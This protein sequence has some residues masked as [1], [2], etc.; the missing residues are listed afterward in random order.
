MSFEKL[1]LI[2]PLL[3]ALR[4][5]GYTEPTPIQVAAIPAVLAGQDVLG[6]A[7]TGTGKTAAFALPILQRM[8]RDPSVP[9]A[10]RA[11]KALVL[12]P[13]REL[14]TQ[15]AES[16]A[17]YG[18]H[19]SLRVDVVF[20][21]VGYPRQRES[22]RRGV[23]ILVATP[24][25]LLDLMSE[26]SIAFPELDVL[27]LD[28]A[29]RMLDMGFLPDVK[30]ILATLPK[31][32]QT[33]FF[34]ATMP[35]EIQALVDSLLHKPVRISV[36]PV[37][38]TA[39]KIDQSVYFVENS[40]KPELLAHLLRDAAVTRALVFTRTK[41]GADRVAKRLTQ[42]GLRSDA[43]H[44][45]KSQ[46]ARERVL[47]DFKSGRGFILVA[48]DIAARGIDVKDISHVV[49]YELPNEPESYVHRIGRTARADASGIAWSLC[50]REEREY[51]TRIQKLIKQTIPA[52][53]G[54]PYVSSVSHAPR[55]ATGKPER[56]QGGGSGHG[57]GPQRGTQRGGARGARPAARSAGPQRSHAPTRAPVRQHA[58]AAAPVKARD[59]HA[60]GT[61]VAHA[62]TART[63]S[64][65]PAA[66]RSPASHPHP[67]RPRQVKPEAGGER[68]HG[69]PAR[70][71]GTHR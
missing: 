26:R 59:E 23:D 70:P 60:F 31:K 27:V 28:E 43:I 63:P 25:R 71:R 22:L 42:S 21:G 7:Q 18:K 48:T 35:S 14:A 24:G 54:H 41:R 32:R 44:G 68:S 57:R 5:K 8:W 40:D 53:D 58:P 34:S 29:D 61:G 55:H 66:T 46:N 56:K 62:A 4:E 20:G 51:L 69:T 16:F 10:R 33:L 52:V 19:S 39:D 1:D 36:T 6:C 9:H 45:N 2:Q 50:G 15:I 47:K 11:V 37:A 64:H 13:T 17:R 38:A 30:R 67:A 12:C 65:A 49:N 3:R